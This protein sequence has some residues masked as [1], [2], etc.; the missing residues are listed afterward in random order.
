MRRN[1]LLK[2][3]GF[4]DRL[5]AE[6]KRLGLSQSACGQIGAVQRLTQSRYEAQTSVP[7]LEYVAALEQAGADA[8]F[9]LS[10]MRPDLLLGPEEVSI[11]AQCIDLVTALAR[12]QGHTLTTEEMLTSAIRAFHHVKGT[13]SSATNQVKLDDEQAAEL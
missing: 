11:F 3:Q 2:V 1:C 12:Q 7:D 10:G 5:L 8:L 4:G 9:L 6:R 13:P